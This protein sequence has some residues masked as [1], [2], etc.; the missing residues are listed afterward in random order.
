MIR[1]AE[2]SAEQDEVT[3]SIGV[4]TYNHALYLDACLAGCVV[5]TLSQ[6]RIEV[7]ICDDGSADGTAD[8]ARAWKARYPD[9]IRLALAERN[10]GIPSNFNRGLT[11]A[12]G[13]YLC[14]LGGDDIILPGKVQA[15][16]DFLEANSWASGCFHDAEVFMS[17]GDEVIGLFSGLYAGRAAHLESVGPREMLDPRVQMLPSTLMIRRPQSGAKFD[18]RLSFHNDYLFDFEFIEARGPLARIEGA[19]TRYRKHQGS[20]GVSAN[21]DGRI[22]EENLVVLGILLARYPHW[23][24]EIRRRERYYLLVQALRAAHSGDRGKAAR[25]GRALF[26]RGFWPTGLAVL[27]GGGILAKLG[28]PQLRGLAIRLRSIF[29]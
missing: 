15:Q 19:Y 16:F 9:V 18:T 23:A 12:T 6:G 11:A 22:L 21:A 13:R 2:H 27:L 14:W 7:V 3:V 29:G 26:G 17:P 28:Q 20:I 10:E 25:F 5:Q 1:A 8:I 24:R 4:I